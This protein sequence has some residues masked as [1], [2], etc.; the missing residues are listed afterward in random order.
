MTEIAAF[1]GILVVHAEDPDVI[2]AHGMDASRSYDDFLASRPPEAETTAIGTVIAAARATGCR[3]HVVHLSAAEALP[4]IAAARAEGVR[5]TVETCPHYLTLAAETVPDGQTQFKCCP[6]V[7]GA[8]NADL[9][10]AALLD[11]AIDCVV[12]DHSPCTPDLKG[13][14]AGDFDAAWGGI[15]SLQL[16]LPLVW[17]EAQRRGVDLATVVGWMSAGPARVVGV[18][19]TRAPRR[20]RAARTS[21]SSHPTR[22]WTV[23][24]AELQHRNAITPYEGR[25]VTGRVRRT[26]LD[27]HALEQADPPRG[28]LLSRAG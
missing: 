12:S 19:A 28:H 3:A 25:E 26:Y 13:L 23:R 8:A 9:L 11:G 22:R 17:T 5:L 7:R 4:E 1:D 27:G 21:S 16:G 2:A 24:A 10:W 18:P 20:R 15:S 14:D 6:P